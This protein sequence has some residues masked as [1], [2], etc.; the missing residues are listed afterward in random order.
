MS[1]LTWMPAV[2]ARV[3]PV[4]RLSS[5][6]WA[7]VMSM[8]T[9]SMLRAVG[10]AVVLVSVASAV[11]SEVALSLALVLE[12][13]LALVDALEVGVEGTGF[14]VLPQALRASKSAVARV[15]R[16]VWVCMAALGGACVFLILGRELRDSFEY[17][18]VAGFPSRCG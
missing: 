8:L 9:A 15:A 14:D 3:R 16:R 7:L 11:L 4:V 2:P 6:F 17:T 5:V 12:L 13:A 18:R 1:R 10:V